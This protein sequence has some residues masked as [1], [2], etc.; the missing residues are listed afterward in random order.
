MM[1][2]LLISSC[3]NLNQNSPTNYTSDF[4]SRYNQI[5][6]SKGDSDIKANVLVKKRIAANEVDYNCNCLKVKELYCTLG[7]VK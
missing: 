2:P 5:I 7:I 3:A 4:C 6:Q 1:I